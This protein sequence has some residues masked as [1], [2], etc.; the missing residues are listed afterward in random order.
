MTATK[1]GYGIKAKRADGL[2]H[3]VLSAPNTTAQDFEDALPAMRLRAEQQG[4][5]TR[6][7]IVPVVFINGKVELADQP[8]ASQDRWRALAD[9]L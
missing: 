7:S 4:R 3:I 2:E 6:Y 5:G 8:N 1:H 9:K